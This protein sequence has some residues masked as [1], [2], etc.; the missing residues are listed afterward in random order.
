M[1]AQKNLIIKCSK[2]EKLSYSES[3][4]FNYFFKLSFLNDNFV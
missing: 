3:I 1:S 2:P 4:N